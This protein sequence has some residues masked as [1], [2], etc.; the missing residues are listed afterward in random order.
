[1]AQERPEDRYDWLY[2]SD[3]G[4]GEPAPTRQ[5]P[6]ASRRRGD[7]LPPPNLKICKPLI[8]WHLCQSKGHPHL[9]KLLELYLK[10]CMCFQNYLLNLYL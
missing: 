6:A 4:R 1:M 3:G 10:F 8:H 7:D 2:G 9:K 5:Q